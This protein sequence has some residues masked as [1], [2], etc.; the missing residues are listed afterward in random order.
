MKKQIQLSIDHFN[1]L[2]PGVKPACAGRKILEKLISCM[3]MTVSFA[4][5]I[6]DRFTDMVMKLGQSVAG[7]EKLWG[8]TGNSGNLRLVIT[9]PDKIG[10]WFYQLC[11][12]RKN[13]LPFLLSL[14]MH[15]STRNSVR[16]ASVVGEWIDVM[17]QIG[18]DSVLPG[19][20]P[21]PDCYLACDS[22]YVDSNSRQLLFESGIKFTTSVKADRFKKEVHL[23]HPEGHIDQTGEW[24][25]IYNDNTNEL[26][27]YHYDTQRESVK[28]TIIP[29][30]SFVALIN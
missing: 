26:F 18:R 2:L 30:D 29:R 24:K 16:V 4:S 14:K 25:G 23:V 8:F 6:S 12:M 15:N 5:L 3:H 20:Q 21:N 11:G 13:N 1:A 17:K 27:V 7:D 22:Y 28:S 19:V 10:F 9:K